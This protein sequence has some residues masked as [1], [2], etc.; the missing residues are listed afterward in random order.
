MAVDDEGSSSERLYSC[1]L[2]RESVIFLRIRACVCFCAFIFIFIA[3]F[4]AVVVVVFLVLFFLKAN[5][6]FYSNF[7]NS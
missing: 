4:I 2:V 6:Y 7:S 3:P 5:K 1:A